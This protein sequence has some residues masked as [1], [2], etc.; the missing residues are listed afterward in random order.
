M[1]GGYHQRAAL[2]N[3]GLIGPALAVISVFMVVPL[4][5]MAIGPIDGRLFGA[6]TTRGKR[7]DVDE[8]VSDVRTALEPQFAVTTDDRDYRDKD[9]GWIDYYNRARA[10][11]E[12]VGR[13]DEIAGQ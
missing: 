10:Q 13:E 5:L 2:R 1:T 9:D 6:P 12:A 3:A 7:K 8:I 11:C 4:M